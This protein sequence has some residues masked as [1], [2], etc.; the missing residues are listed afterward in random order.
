[1][2]YQL[3]NQPAIPGNWNIDGEGG[4]PDP[5]AV[6]ERAR[7]ATPPPIAPGLLGIPGFGSPTNFT[8]TTYNYY[9]GQWVT[10]GLTLVVARVQRLPDH[11]KRPGP[12]DLLLAELLLE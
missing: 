6:H 4:D 12:E 10:S 2:L 1:M 8:A 9:T 7:E 11:R 5:L 3:N